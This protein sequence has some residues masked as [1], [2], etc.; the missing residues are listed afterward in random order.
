MK[1]FNCGAIFDAED[2]IR[3]R[4]GSGEVRRG[5]PVCGADDMDE[6]EPCRI[7]GA[8]FTEE[9]LAYGFCLECLWNAIDY[10]T[11]LAYLKETDQLCEFLFKYWFNCS[12]SLTFISDEFRNH[13]EETFRRIAA[14]EKRCSLTDP[15]FLNACRTML[16]PK[17]PDYFGVDGTDFAGWYAEHEEYWE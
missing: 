15:D 6:T 4:E 17:Y 10:E 9:D 14:D 5:C 16:L 3:I 13:M 7:C 12:G 2:I 8:E 1:C 11:A